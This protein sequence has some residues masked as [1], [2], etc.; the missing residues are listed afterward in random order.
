V[1]KILLFFVTGAGAG[2]VPGFPGT[3]G[4]LVAV[5]VLVALN[6][7]TAASWLLGL[8]TLAAFVLLAT[9]LCEKGEELF[10]A[11]DASKIVI[12]EIAGFLVAGFLLPPSP[13]ALA[14]GFLL[15][16]LFDIIKVYPAA[17]VEGMRGGIGVIADDLVAGA[18]TFVMLR[19]LSAWDWL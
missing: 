5:P 14:V 13:V 8:L 11:K 19:V 9:W 18:Y 15:F 16:R 12:D 1:Q 3:A 10:A 7:L 6:R 17:R 4:T 2:Y